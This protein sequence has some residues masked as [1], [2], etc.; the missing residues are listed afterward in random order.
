MQAEFA[1]VIIVSTITG[2]YCL[3]TE[4]RWRTVGFVSCL[5]AYSRSIIDPY[6]I[7]VIISCFGVGFWTYHSTY[8]IT[9]MLF[10]QPLI[11]L[12][13]AEDAECNKVYDHHPQSDEAELGADFPNVA[14]FGG[15]QAQAVNNG[16][17]WQV[18]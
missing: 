6:I 2:S 14:T 15:Q 17:K 3:G 9:L 10:L 7:I 18:G 4:V 12:F 1:Y 16:G 13:P 5:E 11:A 8:Y